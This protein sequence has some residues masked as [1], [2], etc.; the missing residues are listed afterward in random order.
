MAILSWAWV[1]CHCKDS[2]GVLTGREKPS[3]YA[4]IYKTNANFCLFWLGVYARDFE[5]QKNLI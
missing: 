4:L 3:A 2:T 1:Q 5:Y